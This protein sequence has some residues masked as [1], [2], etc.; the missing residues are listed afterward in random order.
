VITDEADM[1]SIHYYRERA[2]HY[3]RAAEE[4]DE[5]SLREQF[6]VVARDY[7]DFADDFER[8]ILDNNT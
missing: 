3:R 8:R 5:A 7:D 1:N 4:A 6:D 2:E